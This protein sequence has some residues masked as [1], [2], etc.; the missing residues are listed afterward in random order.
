V[1]HGKQVFVLAPRELVVV[2]DSGQ[3]DWRFPLPG[4]P[5][6]RDRFVGVPVVHG[7]R[8]VVASQFGSVEP[9]PGPSDAVGR[10]FTFDAATGRL[11]ECVT[12]AGGFSHA[13]SIDYVTRKLCALRTNWVVCW[14]LDTGR[15]H[16]TGP[17]SRTRPPAAIGGGVLLPCVG[18]G[19]SFFRD[20]RQVWFSDGAPTAA[21]AAAGGVAYIAALTLG[22]RSLVMKAVDLDTGRTRWST[23]LPQPVKVEP[24][25]TGGSVYCLTEASL[26]RLDRTTGAIGWRLTL[27]L[28]NGET[29]TELLHQDN[30]LRVTGPGFVLR[31][32][33]RPTPPAVPPKLV[34]PGIPGL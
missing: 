8:V 22:G 17:A 12:V 10:L 29:V 25:I 9:R 18:A 21:P 31:V 3:I 5:D 24:A 34:V 11:L 14:D 30:E 7:P 26:Y 16:W 27:P 15:E 28:E 32:R 6:D 20:G 23:T 2:N 1:R 33:N 4:K 13:P 19:V